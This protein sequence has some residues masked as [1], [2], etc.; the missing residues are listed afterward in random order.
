MEDLRNLYAHN[1]VGDADEEYFNYRTRHV[2]KK[3]V[4][5]Q[6]KCGG[7]FNGR[8]ASLDLPH[9][10]KYAETVEGLLKRVS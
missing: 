2:L 7:S 4:N 10:R 5:T 6:L 1:Y 8:Q 3:D 9:L